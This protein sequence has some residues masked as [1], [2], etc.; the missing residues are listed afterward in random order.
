MR[1]SSLLFLLSTIILFNLSCSST[2]RLT[3]GV[4]TP[5]R[6]AITANVTK[7]G[8]INRSIPSEENNKLDKLDKILSLE[9]LNL[10]KEGAEFALNGLLDEL[11]RDDRFEI[12]KIIDDVEAQRKGL[13]VFPAALPSELV[14][15]ICKDNDVDILF[16]LEFYDTDTAVDYELG[17]VNVPNNI[18]INIGIPGHKLT[19][20]TVVKNGW[21]VYDPVT[22]SLLDEYIYNDYLTSVGEGINPV[23]AFEAIAGRKEGVMQISSNIGVDY[24]LL[25]RPVNIRVARD[26]FVRGTNNFKIAMRRA[27]TGNWDGAADL[28]AAELDNQK[29]KVAG[30]AHYNMAIINEINGDLEKALEFASAS[31]SDYETRL[32]LTYVNILKRRIAQQR[33][34]ETTFDQLSR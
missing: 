14:E 25:T 7:I 16:S 28:W 1:K 19:L 33:Q 12:V 31:Y 27:R 20:N 32:A 8:I 13:G 23:K 26:Y 24:G 29:M 5:P 22:K 34:L 9:G 21:R 6:I 15:E 10:D 2:N 17:T 4:T 18:G 30:R 11:S 3:M